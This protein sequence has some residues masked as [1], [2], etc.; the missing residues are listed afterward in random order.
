MHIGVGVTDVGVGV[1]VGVSGQNKGLFK[2]LEKKRRVLFLLNRQ[3][4]ILFVP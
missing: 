2:S 3:K 1:G 4:E